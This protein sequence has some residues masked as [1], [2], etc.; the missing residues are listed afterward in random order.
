M[1]SWVAAIVQAVGQDVGAAGNVYNLH[2]QANAAET[3]A[4]RAKTAAAEA[5]AQGDWQAANQELRAGR[6]LSKQTAAAGASGFDI[7]SESYRDVMAGSAQNYSL[8]IRQL[9]R[10]AMLASQTYQQQ[11]SDYRQ[12]ADAAR[13]SAV[14]TVIGGALANAGSAASSVSSFVD[15]RRKNNKSV[16]DPN[17]ETDRTTLGK[18]GGFS[19]DDYFKSVARVRGY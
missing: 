11:A 5:A 16:T 4:I 2:Q 3:S 19:E 14:F 7:N 6:M 8:D 15:E 12:A 1:C 13:T 10:N 17:P 18:G 9:R